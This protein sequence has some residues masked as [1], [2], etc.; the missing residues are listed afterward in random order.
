MAKK[1]SLKQ[2]TGKGFEEYLKEIESIVDKLESGE[3]NLDASIALYER[4]MELVE[5]CRE[6]L[7]SAKLKIEKLKKKTES[8]YTSAPLDEEEDKDENDDEDDDE[9]NDGKLPF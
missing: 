2:E 4:G 7:K 1:T 6:S 5:K 9:E 8:G 3:L